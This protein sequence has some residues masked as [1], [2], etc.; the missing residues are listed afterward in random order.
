MPDHDRIGRL[1]EEHRAAAIIGGGHGR[2]HFARVIG[3]VAAH[4]VDPAHRESTAA[5]DRNAGLLGRGD[6][7]GHARVLWR[8]F[9]AV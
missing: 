9:A 3:E 6:Y 8:G 1:A 2:A 7:I 5:G 4:T